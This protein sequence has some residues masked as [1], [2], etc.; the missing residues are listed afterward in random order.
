VNFNLENN[1]NWQQQLAGSFANPKELLKFLDL[2]L[3]H[4]TKKK[5]A[6]IEFPFKVTHSFASRMAKRDIH[7]PLLAQVLPVTGELDL[8]HGFSTN[9]VGDLEATVSPGVLH[10]YHGRVLLIVTAACAINCRYC[11]RREFPYRNGS[12]SPAYEQMGLEYISKNADIN[13]VI[14]SG[15]DPLMLNDSKLKSLIKKIAAIPHIIRLRVHTRLPIVL[16]SRITAELIETLS[17]TRLQTV[18][19]LHTNH[20]NEL[21][22]EIASAIGQLTDANIPLLNQSVLLKG[23]N[24]DATILISLSEALFALNVLPYYLHL[25]DKTKG[26]LHFA[27]ALPKAKSIQKRLRQKLP[28]FLVPRMVWEKSGEAFKLPL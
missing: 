2:D 4:C 12:F 23:V 26:T 27:T 20:P 22:R 6:N 21:D 10:K 18:L 28:G 16:P 3:S 15:G 9:P 24:D 13:E 1:L 17:E 5:L 25:L 11:F 14:L 8:S 19:V 7:D